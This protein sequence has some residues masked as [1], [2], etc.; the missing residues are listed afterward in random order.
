MKAKPKTELAHEFIERFPRHSQ[1]AIAHALHAE[2]PKRFT[3]DEAVSLVKNVVLR[4]KG[5]LL[6]PVAYDKAN[7]G[8]VPPALP[9]SHAKPWLPFVVDHSKGLRV[10]I[11]SDI[12]IPYHDDAAVA[13]ALDQLERSNVNLILLNGDLCD[14]YRISKWEQ[15]PEKRT[16][17]QEIA[18]IRQFLAHLRHRFPRAE[19]I[20][21][22]GNHEERLWP[23]IWR[24]CPELLGIDAL[25][26]GALIHA[27]KHGVEIVGEQRI[28]MLGKLPVLHGHEMP[29]GIT[30]PVNP[31]RGMF[32]RVSDRGLMGHLHRTSEHTET[33]M[34]DRTITCWSTGCLCDMNP[35]YARLNK[36]NH[37]FAEVAVSRNGEFSVTNH[38]IRHGRIL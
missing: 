25:S 8:K 12:H 22:L 16:F 3:L 33:T 36:W 26:F 32:L 4:N 7:A 10:G 18:D 11:L 20:L 6:A 34:L 19:I 24:K 14:F 28:I 30:S 5:K 23:Y 29:K 27:D 31:A 17:A 9:K 2:H 35:E 37:G 13:C 38:R 21:K 1:R 15:D